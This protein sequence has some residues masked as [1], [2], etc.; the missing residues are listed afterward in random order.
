M[1]TLTLDG[2]GLR[3]SKVISWDTE[4]RGFDWST[5]EQ[6][7]FMITWADGDGEYAAWEHDEEAIARFKVAV[8]EADAIVAHNAKFDIHQVRATFGFDPSEGKVLHDTD[9][10]SRVLHPEGAKKGA[11]GGHGLK[12]NAQIYLRADAKD[13][14]E[15][16]KQMAK[17]IGLR[18]IKQTGAYFEVARAYPEVMEEYARMDARYTYDLLDKWLPQLGDLKRIYDMEMAVL[19]ILVRA[20]QRGVAVD[21]DVVQAIKARFTAE[22]AEV[23]ERLTDSL[24]EQALGGEG[25]DEALIE[26]LLM[27]G[28]P[29]HKK[30]DSGKLATN[31]FALQEFERDYPVIADLFEHR[32]LSRFL[33]TYIGAMDGRDIV[34]TSFNQCEAWTGRMSSRSPN[35]QNLPKRA[36]QEVRSVFVPREG[37]SFVI[38]DYEGIEVRLLAY[39]LG[40]PDFRE[41]V[42]SGEHDPHAWMCTNIWG[43]EI[44]DYVKGS[45]K[46]ISHRQPAKNILFAITY[47][48]GGPRVHAMLR[49]ADF[50]FPDDV[51]EITYA[52]SVASKIKSNLPGYY[53]LMK[54]VRSKIENVGYVNTIMGRKNPVS[55]EKSYVGLNALIQGSAADIMK[56][57]L[58]N[59]DAAVKP[60]G[61]I[62]LLVVHDEVV[63]EVPSENADEALRLTEQALISAYDLNPHLAV[64]GKVVTTSYADG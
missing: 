46:E 33:S 29:L 55:K 1:N 35:M 50:E 43:G 21:Q 11:M 4:T 38:C 47:G 32:R 58:I 16:I 17:S 64:S 60:L 6:Q 22:L 44:S 36:G 20:E 41:L 63:V 2:L 54:R 19:P 8:D 45:A 51:D 14:E 57:G 26:A 5:P 31:K 39:Y 23:H 3:M 15:A 9:L 12:A 37:H 56:Q 40:D 27:Q 7:A 13:P 30:T 42:G 49:D 52:K 61:G 10:L 25:S 34:H 18:T 48:A 59:V 24:G 53:K 62:P 28:I